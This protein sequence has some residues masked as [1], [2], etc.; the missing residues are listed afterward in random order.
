MNATYTFSSTQT[1]TF[2]GGA[3]SITVVT[4]GQWWFTDATML[5]AA[6]SG[7]WNVIAST[8]TYAG[9]HGNGNLQITSI[10][11]SGAAP[12][13]TDIYEGYLHY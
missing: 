11:F 5:H 2:S 9:I 6:G 1:F 4:S 8:G 10:D 3:G 12:A 13:V 7:N